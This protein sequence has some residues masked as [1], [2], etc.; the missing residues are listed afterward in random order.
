MLELFLLLGRG[1]GM[2][3]ELEG[4]GSGIGNFENGPLLGK[5]GVFW[6]RD[7]WQNLRSGC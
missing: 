4:G 5:T 3:C 7:R 2:E 1:F 6:C